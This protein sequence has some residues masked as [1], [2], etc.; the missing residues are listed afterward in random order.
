MKPIRKRFRDQAIALLTR[1]LATDDGKSGMAK[2]LGGLLARRSFS[3][4]DRVLEQAPYHD[5]TWHPQQSPACDRDVVVISSRFRSGSTLLWNI[6]REQRGVTAYYEPFNERRWF[7]TAARGSTVDSTHLNVKDY[8][9]EYDELSELGD[10][11]REEWIDQD[12]F[13]DEHFWNGAMKR[14]IEI[15]IERSSGLPVLQ[16]NRVDFRL[17]WLRRNFRQAKLVHLYRHPRDQWCSMLM[18]IGCYPKDS[19]ESFAQH[20]KFYLLRWAD[21]LKYHFPFLADPGLHPYQLHYFIWKLSYLFGAQYSDL[22][23]SFEALVER[24]EEQLAPLF[25]LI[26]LKD[27]FDFRGIAPLIE[28]PTV[29][30]WRRYADEEWFMTRERYCDEVLAD[31]VLETKTAALNR[32]RAAV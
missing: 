29:G 1:A 24:P 31:F 20:D 28:R 27:Q 19:A 8:W 5:L 17:P 30:K 6:L 13:M 10:Y 11:Y 14:Y 32:L 25:D 26:G 7:D 2:S 21:D 22:S 3:F 23:V 18:D 9:R 16:F 4:D 12:L 15:L